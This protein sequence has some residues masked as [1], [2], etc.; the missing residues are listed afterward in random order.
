MRRKLRK[1]RCLPGGEFVSKISCCSELGAV[2][3][4]SG[5]QSSAGV[6]G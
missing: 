4:R 1:M 5:F 2:N 6:V 3:L